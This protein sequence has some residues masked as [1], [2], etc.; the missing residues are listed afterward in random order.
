MTQLEIAIATQDVVMDGWILVV[1]ESNGEEAI[2]EAFHPGK[3]RLATF[4][5]S[6]DFIE[7]LMCKA[8]EIREIQSKY[9]KE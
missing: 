3:W 2:G 9:V 5:S 6:E 4:D 8:K 1:S 7:W